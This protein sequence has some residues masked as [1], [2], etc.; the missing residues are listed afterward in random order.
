LL[1]SF[2]RARDFFWWVLPIA[3]CL[4]ISTVYCRYHY[5]VDVIAGAVL[6]LIAV[7]VGDRLYDRAVG[8]R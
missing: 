2:R 1:V 4:V 8:S 5:L 3:V 7:P 6:A